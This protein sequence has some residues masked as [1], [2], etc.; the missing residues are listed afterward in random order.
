MY[1]SVLYQTNSGFGLCCW[2]IFFYRSH[3]IHCCLCEEIH[4]RWR[5]TCVDTVYT[6]CVPLLTCAVCTQVRL[7]LYMVAHLDGVCLSALLNSMSEDHYSEI[8]QFRILFT[9]IRTTCIQVKWNGHN[10][11][12]NYLNA[13]QPTVWNVSECINR[14]AIHFFKISSGIQLKMVASK[15]P[16]TTSIIETM[17]SVRYPNV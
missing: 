2:Q 11:W 6:F 14:N 5:H 9:H 13:F 10:D 12:H 16:K 15:E 1:F 8:V 4:F 3:R 7:Y 17:K